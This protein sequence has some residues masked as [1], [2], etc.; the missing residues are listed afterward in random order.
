MKAI[1]RNVLLAIIISTFAMFGALGGSAERHGRVPKK[2]EMQK[3]WLF[4]MS[5]G[6]KESLTC[7]AVA[8]TAWFVCFWRCAMINKRLRIEQE[9]KMHFIENMRRSSYQRL[10]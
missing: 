10:Y 5:E 8:V 4:E 3:L 6:D 2:E 9:F 1:R 7:I